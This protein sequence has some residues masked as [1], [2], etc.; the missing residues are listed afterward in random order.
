MPTS[1]EADHLNEYLRSILFPSQQPPPPRR[2][3]RFLTFDQS[4]SSLDGHSI[5]PVQSVHQNHLPP[6][7]LHANRL[8]QIRPAATA[9]HRR[10]LLDLHRQAPRLRPLHGRPPLRPLPNLPPAIAVDSFPS[11]ASLSLSCTDGERSSLTLPPS[12][13]PTPP[14]RGRGTRSP[15]SSS[16]TSASPTDPPR[17]APG[18]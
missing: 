7:H 3:P 14:P 5:I 1:S 17:A 4:P 15:S 9:Y 6:T 11:T 13:P 12:S 8:L 16:R 2:S 18:S 10:S